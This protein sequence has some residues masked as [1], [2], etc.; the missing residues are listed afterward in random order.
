MFDEAAAHQSVC[1]D[2]YPY[3]TSSTMLLPARIKQ[4]D[5]VLVTWSKVDPSAA[6]QSLFALAKQR[7]IAP[8]ALA[9][10]LSPAGAVYFAMSEDNVSR[11]LAHP[12]CMIGS[13]GL[14]HDVQP[15]PRLWGCVSAHTRP[16]RASGVW[17]PRSTR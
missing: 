10:Q 12:M 17:R 5:D 16:L 9:Q 11:I 7:D 1:F 14:A 13:D 2:C 6:G 15:H 8:E 4:S 3:N